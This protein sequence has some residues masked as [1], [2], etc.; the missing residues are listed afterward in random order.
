[1]PLPELQTSPKEVY[2][3]RQIQRVSRNRLPGPLRVA[4]VIR[5]V[6]TT[7]LLAVLGP[8]DAAPASGAGGWL[9]DGDWLRGY[10]GLRFALTFPSNKTF[11]APFEFE[12]NPPFD[13]ANAQLGLDLSRYLS[14]ELALDYYEPPYD[15]QGIDGG[16]GEITAYSIVPQARLRYPLFQD[17]LVPYLVG[18]VGIGY[19]ELS[20]PRQL[21]DQP[22]VP[23]L[24]G[25]DSAIAG[26]IGLGADYFVANNVALNLE[27]KQLFFRPTLQEV[28]RGNPEIPPQPIEVNLDATILSAGLRLFFPQAAP[29]GAFPGRDWRPQ[30]P[31]GPRG[32]FGLRFGGWWLQDAHFSQGLTAQTGS[33]QQQL[34]SIVLGAD[35]TR[36]LG[37]ELAIDYYETE[38]NSDALGVKI[39]EMSVW[40]FLAQ[41]RARYPLLEH[42]LVPY[43][44]AGVGFGFNEFNDTTAIGESPEGPKFDSRDFAPAASLGLGLD[45]FVADNIALEVETKYLF[46]RP[47]IKLQ[48]GTTNTANLDTLFLGL[49]ARVFFP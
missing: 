27:V 29:A 33:G 20:D 47:D 38:V 5:L 12:D 10:V 17:R 11:A 21:S 9:Y 19:S 31:E 1:M 42:R 16:I 8:A 28:Y 6:V 48:D 34:S 45:Y 26:T 43:A 25:K 39:N 35:T 41:V 32:Y 3:R 13:S 4:T 15:V 7:I 49:G 14:L 40:D 22:G 30:H 46:F 36:Y 24:S 2:A 37:I 23:S 44:L 18:G